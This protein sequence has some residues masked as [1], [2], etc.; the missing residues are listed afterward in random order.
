MTEHFG[1]ISHDFPKYEA[2]AGT[3]QI[4]SIFII[5]QI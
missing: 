2:C 1:Q 5:E 3:Q 4:I